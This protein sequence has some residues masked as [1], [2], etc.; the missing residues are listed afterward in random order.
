LVLARTDS[1]EADILW[2]DLAGPLNRT[3]A[4]K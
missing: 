3:T 1:R 4:A 2:M